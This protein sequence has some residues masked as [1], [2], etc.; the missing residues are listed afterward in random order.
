M[1]AVL[2]VLA[3]LFLVVPIVEL[4]IIVQVATGIGVLET[5]GLLILVSIA[6]AWLVRAQGLGVLRRV[7]AQLGQGRVPGKEL[8]DGMLILFAGA[9]M[10]TPGFLTDACGLVL[11]VPP[12][13]AIARTVI[14]HRYRDR[15]VVS[16]PGGTWYRSGGSAGGSFIDVDGSPPNDD[17]DGSTEPPSLG[18]GPGGR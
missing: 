15:V 14:I 16:G 1:D 8:I 13:R 6:G 3:L 7:Q 17:D 10:L 11:L 12:T 4:Y 18:S 9:L 5:L 2:G